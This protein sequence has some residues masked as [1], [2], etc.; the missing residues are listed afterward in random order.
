MYFLDEIA[1]GGQ[2][3]VVR[4]GCKQK[5]GGFTTFV[6]KISEGGS[7]VAKDV[8][9]CT[10]IKNEHFGN[11]LGAETLGSLNVIAMEEAV[12]SL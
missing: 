5:L 10:Q 3:N 12:E 11:V 4:V 7:Y 2:A 1:R 9:K 6:L 8:K